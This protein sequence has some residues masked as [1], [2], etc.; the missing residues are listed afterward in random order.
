MP[1]FFLLTLIPS[2][3]RQ[4]SLVLGKIDLKILKLA[5][6]CEQ[7]TAGRATNNFTLCFYVFKIYVLCF[8][9]SRA[10]TRNCNC[11]YT[12][13]VC[14]N[15]ILRDTLKWLSHDSLLREVYLAIL[16]LDACFRPLWL[17]RLPNCWSLLRSC[18]FYY[19]SIGFI[20]IPNEG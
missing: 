5:R 15:G 14:V 3:F 12:Q 10:V 4:C 17:N 20:Y 6:C 9:M 13:G 2:Y 11:L 8:K 7:N 19:K 1:S 18:R 16:P